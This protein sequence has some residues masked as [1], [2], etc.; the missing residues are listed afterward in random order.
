MSACDGE[1]R[2]FMSPRPPASTGVK[3]A[4]KY[5]ASCFRKNPQHFVDFMHPGDQPQTCPSHSGIVRAPTSALAS[6]QVT[7]GTE[8]DPTSSG[9]R[10]KFGCGRPAYQGRHRAYNT[11][12]RRCGVC[13]GGGEHDEHCTAGA[14][15]LGGASNASGSA[16]N[17][18]YHNESSEDAEATALMA[19]D[20][21]LE[22]RRRAKN[23]E[24]AGHTGSSS[25]L[26]KDSLEQLESA[27]AKIP[28]HS[29]LSRLLDS[30]LAA[31]H[32]AED[33]ASLGTLEEE[34]DTEV[35]R[36]ITELEGS[37]ASLIAAKNAS[38]VPLCKFGC[39]FPANPSIRGSGK[40]FQ[41][42]CRE[43]G[44]CRGAGSHDEECTG[45]PRSTALVPASTALA[46]APDALEAHAG[47]SSAE[48]GIVA[49]EPAK[50]AL[51]TLG[52][53]DA[54]PT[55]LTMREIRRRYMRE[56][57]A[58]HPDK[59]PP[60]EKEQRTARFQE[61]AEAYSKLELCMELLS[62]VEVEGTTGPAHSTMGS[63]SSASAASVPLTLP[64]SAPVPVSTMPCISYGGLAVVLES[65][66]L[67]APGGR[68]LFGCIL[69][70]NR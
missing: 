13:Q 24:R 25:T 11:C 29:K 60:E 12:C 42:C 57:L 3:P 23:L 46:V 32:R 53:D 8:R 61:L 31:W 66:P 47:G 27:R 59:G 6:E 36:L 44:R 33:E 43:C 19:I 17:A 56:C 45:T 40:A 15:E 49:E 18:A 62:R 7:R 38:L 65:E 58:W 1:A 39:G 5:G 21:A 68:G 4:C 64:E 28:P 70:C 10:C 55:D 54:W 34:V 67:N 22:L 14:S 69:G 16:G 37:L 26:L 51:R 63:A 9:R 20:Y 30:I 48:G 41:T 35:D 50:A 2:K 52:L